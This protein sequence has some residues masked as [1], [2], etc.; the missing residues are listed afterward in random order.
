M[1]SQEKNNL[2]ADGVKIIIDILKDTVKEMDRGFLSRIGRAANI[3]MCNR[4]ILSMEKI[5]SAMRRG[6]HSKK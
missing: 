3:E 6:E 2:R 4:M 1:D 5:E